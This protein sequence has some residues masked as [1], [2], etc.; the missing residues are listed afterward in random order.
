MVLPRNGWDAEPTVVRSAWA[1]IAATSTGLGTCRMSLH[2]RRLVA[3][4]GATALAAALALTAAG[5]PAALPR[6]VTASS[7]TDQHSSIVIAAPGR[8]AEAA[9]AVRASGG[10]IGKPLAIINGFTAMVPA[11]ASATLRSSA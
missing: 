5:G 11:S 8:V 6:I 1:V 4:T 10:S 7:A 2:A 9:A 3:A